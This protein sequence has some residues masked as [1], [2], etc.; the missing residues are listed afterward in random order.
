MNEF[1]SEIY[2]HPHPSHLPNRLN[3]SS[4]HSEVEDASLSP[5]APLPRL[6]LPSL[7]D[8]ILF[9]DVDDEGDPVEC[10]VVRGLPL[11]ADG[12]FE[13]EDDPGSDSRYHPPV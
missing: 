8:A 9:D 2:I 1:K 10:R 12:G 13:A 5:A 7:G 11:D 4:V 3:S 6:V